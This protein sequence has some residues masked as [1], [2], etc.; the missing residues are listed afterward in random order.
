MPWTARG[1]VVGL[2][3]SSKKIMGRTVFEK[4][5]LH[6][7]VSFDRTSKNNMFVLRFCNDLSLAFVAGLPMAT[8]HSRSSVHT[9]SYGTKGCERQKGMRNRKATYVRLSI[10]QRQRR[11]TI[12][13]S[14]RDEPINTPSRKV[15]LRC[16]W[17]LC[18]PVSLENQ[19]GKLDKPK[20]LKQA[21]KR[22]ASE[23]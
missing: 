6:G 18:F 11:L 16:L 1:G 19:N 2:W 21:K 5:R 10:R 3:R 12:P 13:H 9:P 17:V 14:D 20:E 7:V 4:L 22:H 23:V 8:A 15:S